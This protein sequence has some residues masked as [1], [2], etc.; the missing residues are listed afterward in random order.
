MLRVLLDRRLPLRAVRRRA[1]ALTNIVPRTT[2]EAAELARA[3]FV[4]GT[5][6][7]AR[8]I[9]RVEP[10]VV[11]FV[12][13]TVYRAFFGPRVS[14]GVGAEARAYRA[15]ARVCAAEPERAQR[16]LSRLP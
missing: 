5:R 1:G 16:R 3:E 6:Q 4:A 14:G 8:L 15:G 7:L 13:T 2:R 12:G 11:A 9:V 10:E